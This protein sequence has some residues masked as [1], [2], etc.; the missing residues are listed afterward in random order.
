M[1]TLSFDPQGADFTI[2]IHHF[3]DQA[4]RYWLVP[5]SALAAASGHADIEFTVERDGS[6]SS[7]RLLRSTGSE[8]LDRAARNALI[9]GIFLELP[10]DY[11]APRVTMQVGFDYNEG[12][13]S[14]AP[15]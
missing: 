5:P 12:P 2:W 9:G 4:Y 7:L 3:K 6:V 15:P 11:P 13:G 14:V 8:A 1:G 10:R